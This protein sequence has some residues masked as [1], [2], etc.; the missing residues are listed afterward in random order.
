MSFEPP[1]NFQGVTHRFSCSGDLDY[2]IDTLNSKLTRHPKNAFKSKVHWL[3]LSKT[4]R[5]IKRFLADTTDDTSSTLIRW[6]ISVIEGC[7]ELL[8]HT[9]VCKLWDSL[10]I[11]VVKAKNLNTFNNRL[12]KHWSKHA[13][14]SY[15]DSDP[16][17]LLAHC[18]NDLDQQGT[19]QHSIRY[20]SCIIGI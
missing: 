10:A 2:E 16:N 4:T 3:Q 18:Y 20:A 8:C 17:E 19:I 5:N 6:Q 11:T 1:E 15:D 14:H 12:D 7:K 13:F 9:G